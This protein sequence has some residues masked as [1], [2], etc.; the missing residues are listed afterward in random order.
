MGER[1][2]GRVLAV[3]VGVVEAKG[4]AAQVGNKH[5]GVSHECAIQR[6]HHTVGGKR[7]KRQDAQIAGSL[8]LF[9]LLHGLES[10]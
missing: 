10:L 2:C 5:G 8:V 3:R 9:D 7:Q 1:G 6:P 4:S